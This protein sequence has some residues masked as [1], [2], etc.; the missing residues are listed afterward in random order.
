MHQRIV[1]ARRTP[2]RM[3]HARARFLDG[4]LQK[5]LSAVTDLSCEGAFLE[6]ALD[7]STT[8]RYEI[9]LTLPTVGKTVNVGVRV[10][11]TTDRGVG[12]RFE[13]MSSRTRS[14]LRSYAGYYELDDAMASVQKAL[15]DAVGGNLLPLSHPGEVYELLQAAVDQRTPVTVLDPTRRFR[16]FSARLDALDGEVDVGEPAFVLADSERPLRPGTMAVYIAFFVTPLCYAFE[17]LVREEDGRQTILFPERLYVTERRAA[18]R[19]STSGEVCVL[20]VP[21]LELEVRMPLIERGAKG[22]SI[23]VDDR[24]LLVPG[25]RL[26]AFRIEKADGSSVGVDSATVRYVRKLGVGYR[27]GLRFEVR[28]EREGLEPEVQVRDL[29]KGLWSRWQLRFQKARALLS[30]W[31]GRKR[32]EAAGTQLNVV[33]CRNR[34]GNEV[35]GLLDA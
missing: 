21:Q 7:F 8:D 18:Q 23:Q 22:A 13:S 34:L 2:R 16:S 1:E 4:S 3:T 30:G 20:T 32:D 9:E 11:R 25:M 31:F 15:G 10:M 5:Q 33:R 24:V 12:V 35:V 29:Q 19:N 26:P 14:V 6:S 17:A 28:G 27:A